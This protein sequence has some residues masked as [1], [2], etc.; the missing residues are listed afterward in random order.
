QG[1]GPAQLGAVAAAN[2]GLAGG[3]GTA[4]SVVTDGSS[5]NLTATGQ[6][7]I[8]NVAPAKIGSL[9]SGSNAGAITG[10]T[11]FNIVHNAG[12]KKGFPLFFDPVAFTPIEVDWQFVDANTISVTTIRNYAAGALGYLFLG[13]A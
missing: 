5:I 12:Y 8:K 13:A 1:I 3:N 6:V 2:G 11:P 7:E 10:L 4:L 9:V